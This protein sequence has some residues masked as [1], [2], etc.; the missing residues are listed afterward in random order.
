MAP[1]DR[2]LSLIACRHKNVTFACVSSQSPVNAIQIPGDVTRE[3]RTKATKE[4]RTKTADVRGKGGAGGYLDG[5]GLLEVFEEA[6]GLE[7]VEVGAL[8]ALGL[9]ELDGLVR[10]RP[11]LLRLL[12]AKLLLTF[13]T[14][15]N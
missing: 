14:V 10:E 7:L 3:Q 1:V 9:V 2:S 15:S 13:S 5:E 6:V 11:H 4:K 8:G 12:L